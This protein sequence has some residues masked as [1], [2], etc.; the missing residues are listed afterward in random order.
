MRHKIQINKYIA[1]LV[2]SVFMFNGT[3]WNVEA[4]TSVPFVHAAS[5]CLLDVGSGRILYEK[6]GHEPRRI[7]S[8]TKIVT[9]W[10][11]I[12]SNK[13]DQIVT[14]SANAA[15]QEGSSVYLRAGE[16]IKMR[17]LLYAMMMR[18]G[19]DA[20]MAIAESVAGSSQ[21]FAQL[22]NAEVTH[23]HLKNTHFVN[24]HGL[25]HKDH[26]AS[27]DDFAR[28]TEQALKNPLFRQIVSTKYYRIARSTE[29][30]GMKL[31]NKNKFLWM[32]EHAD[33]V[34]TGYTRAAGRCLAASSSIDGRQVV[35]I[36]LDDPSDWSDAKQLL[37]YGLQAYHRVN[38]ATMTQKEFF[39]PVQD[40]VTQKVKTAPKFSIY[41]PLRSDED[42]KITYRIVQ[43]K[44]IAPIHLGQSLGNLYVSLNHQLIGTTPLLAKEAIP[45]KSWWGKLKGLFSSSR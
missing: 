29:L 3:Q 7:A 40:G 5:A 17:D 37:N 19:N 14:V 23:L 39:L 21:Q 11:A 9:G 1:G 4:A 45:A 43:Q 15:R 34:K 41:Y 16:K 2:I 32:T 18:S 36:V 42:A 44:N 26:Y 22:M 31:K 27:A 33:G 12:K 10:I 38:V 6:N 8:L 28:L 30:Q 13:L 24:P 25:D 20:A 35:L